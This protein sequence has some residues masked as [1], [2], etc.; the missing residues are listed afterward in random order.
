MHSVFSRRHP[1]FIDRHIGNLV[2][3]IT[4]LTKAH[5]S[6]TRPAQVCAVRQD[7]CVRARARVCV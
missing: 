5:T 6:P 3:L 2:R 7:M 4:K 1:T